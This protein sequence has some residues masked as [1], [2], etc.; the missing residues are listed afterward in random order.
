[1]FAIC[2]AISPICTAPAA[3]AGRAQN[4]V[5]VKLEMKIHC[6]ERRQESTDGTFLLEAVS[7][8]NVKV[9]IQSVT[10]ANGRTVNMDFPFN[11][12]YLGSAC[13]DVK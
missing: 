1:M 4:G 11:G 9:T 5:H 2:I 6:E 3:H 12:Q 8:E 7:S 10:N 13:G